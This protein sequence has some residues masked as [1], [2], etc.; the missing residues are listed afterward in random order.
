MVTAIATLLVASQ[1][2]ASDADV[3]VKSLAGIPSIYVQVADV[4][5]DLANA[6]LTTA[7]LQTD[8]ELRLRSAGIRVLSTS[9]Y[10]ALPGNF[11]LSLEVIGLRARTGG[12]GIGYMAAVVLTF[13]Q[14]IHLDRRPGL[15]LPGG[16]WTY[17]GL[18]AGA[19]T[20]VIR[21]QVRDQADLFA[22]AYLTANPK[23]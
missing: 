7:T 14:D 15:S 4:T 12:E 22:N 8:V 9:E 18:A 17:C 11:Y 23:K 2:T 5:G 19:T 13:V 6:G 1:S 3:Y 16:T 21:N 10:Q 20:E